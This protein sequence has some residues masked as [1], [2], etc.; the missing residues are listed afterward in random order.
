MRVTIE[1]TS[2]DSRE[3]PRASGHQGLAQNV[4]IWSLVLAVM[5]CSYLAWALLS[6]G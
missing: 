3:D 5:I 1:L 2:Q 4:W 6:R